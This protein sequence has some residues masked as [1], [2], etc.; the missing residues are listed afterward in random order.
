MAPD[1]ISRDTARRSTWDER[2]TAWHLLDRPD[3]GV[4]EQCLPPGSS[5]RAHTHD[6]S[7]QFFFVLSGEATVVL[8]RQTMTVPAGT[9]IEVP[10]RVSHE[11]RNEGDTDLEMLVVSAPKVAGKPY[12]HRTRPLARS[13]GGLVVGSYLRATR[14]GDLRTVVDIE[15]ALDTRQWIGQGGLEWHAAVL[16]DPRM[17]HWVLV[18]RLD[19][20]LAFGIMASSDQ[21]GVVELRR[22][23][24]AP[25]GRGQGLGRLLLRQLL[26]QARARPQVTTVWLDVGDDN[27]RARSLYRS[28]GFVEKEPPPWAT[29]LDNGLYMEWNATLHEG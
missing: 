29:L 18:D 21:A 20:V 28:F 10:P 5:S 2:C 26:E 27:T 17:E 8:G 24:V 9:G 14:R 13:R 25:E 1:P 15:E 22:T 7:R 3:L 11:L 16:E 12:A 19:R 4:D 23:V 6:R